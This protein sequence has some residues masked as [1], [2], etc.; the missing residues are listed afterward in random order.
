MFLPPPSSRGCPHSLAPG[1]TS[2]CFHHHCSLTDPSASPYK[3][4]GDYTGP[5]QIIQDNLPVTKT[6]I[7]Y[8]KSLLPF[9][10]I[11]LYIPGIRTRTS[12]RTYHSL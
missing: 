7:T 4:S 3:D 2:L 1:T 10:I 12:L 6:L 5:T 9:K 11:Y 8:A